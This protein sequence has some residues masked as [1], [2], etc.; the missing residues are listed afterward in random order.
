MLSPKRR[1]ALEILRDCGP[2]SPAQFAE[3]MWP[4]S[5]CWTHIHKCGNKGASQGVMMAMAGGGF[6]GKLRR[7]GLIM[8][9]GWGPPTR[10]G[11]SLKGHRVLAAKG[12]KR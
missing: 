1:R 5:P 11:L 4:E 10:W 6:L 12:E 3:Y 9:A 8:V 2:I 7:D